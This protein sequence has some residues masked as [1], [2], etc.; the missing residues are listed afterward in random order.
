MAHIYNGIFSQQNNVICSN[1]DATRDYHTKQSKSEKD[2]YLWYHLY[3]KAKI[4]HN[5]SIHEAEPESQR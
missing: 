5:E 2:K 3:V 1:I 4:L